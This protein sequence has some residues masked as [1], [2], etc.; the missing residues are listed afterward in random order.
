MALPEPYLR[1]TVEEY[2]R[3]ERASAERHEYLDGQIYQM[4]GERLEHSTINANVTSS[5]GLQLRGKSCRVL[6]PNMKVRASLKGLYAYPDAA[7]FCGEPQF[8]D[9]RK[10]ILT[11]PSRS[12]NSTPIFIPLMLKA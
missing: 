8:H 11:T 3:G 10:D 5:L 7:V 6:S 4:A 2:L 12:L 9:K 1:A